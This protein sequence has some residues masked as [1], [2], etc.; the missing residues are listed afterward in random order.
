VRTPE[1]FASGLSHLC[2]LTHPPSHPFDL[3]WPRLDHIT[4]HELT[5]PNMTSHDL[6]TSH[7]LTWPCNLT[8]PHLTS[9]DLTWPHLT[10]L[11]LTWPPDLTW[12]ILTSSHHLTCFDLTWPILTS[13]L[14]MTYFDV[15][16]SVIAVG[17]VCILKP[18]LGWCSTLSLCLVGAHPR[19]LPRSS[20]SE[21]GSVEERA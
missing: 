14:H 13:W 3:T 20:G 7:D 4:S 17:T 8:W 11:D 9:L 15:L 12:P 2:H 10:S 6:V 1:S 21:H 5:W 19:A 18:L 16:T